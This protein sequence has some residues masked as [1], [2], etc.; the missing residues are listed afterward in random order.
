M[1]RKVQTV[2]IQYLV[3][4]QLL[5]AAERVLLEA[6]LLAVLV[7]A[8]G[9]LGMPGAQGLLDK[10]I[11]A[12]MGV[13]GHPLRAVAVLVLLAQVLAV[14]LLAEQEAMEQQAAYLVL[15]LLTLA[16]VVVAGAAGAVRA[17]QE[18]ALRVFLVALHLREL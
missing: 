5:S 13:V 12:A 8:Q 10:E 4:L 3:V 2:V 6:A 18:G 15:V 14:V 17:E 16:A 1:A 11:M 9:F 7:V